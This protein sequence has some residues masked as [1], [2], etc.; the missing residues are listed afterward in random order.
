MPL[1]KK[2]KP[3][4]KIYIQIPN[5]IYCEEFEIKKELTKASHS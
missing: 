1:Y 5:V 4:L 2:R 3:N